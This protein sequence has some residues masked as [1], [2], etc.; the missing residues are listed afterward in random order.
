RQIVVGR[1]WNA[2]PNRLARPTPAR[3]REHVVRLRA[4]LIEKLTR[5]LD[6]EDGNL[7]TLS[8]GV[9]SSSLGALAAGVVGRKVWTLSILPAPKDLFDHEMS[10]IQPL[11]R[12][13]GFERQWS[14]L[15]PQETRLT[16]LHSAPRIVFQVI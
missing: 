5:D 16:L 1:D 12:H 10:Y 3:V 8:G 4:L 15:I 14:T 13:F 7:L 9:D 2:R 6:P 11:A